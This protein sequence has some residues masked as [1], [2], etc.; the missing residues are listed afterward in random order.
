MHNVQVGALTLFKLSCHE[1]TRF[2]AG[3]LADGRT[4][5]VSLSYTPQNLSSCVLLC[6]VKVMKLYVLAARMCGEAGTKLNV[7]ELG[8]HS[9]VDLVGI[10]VKR[11]VSKLERL[12]STAV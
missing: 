12:W 11:N 3:R 8:A 4:I 6:A 7:G 2:C 10:K 1:W 5:L 9:L